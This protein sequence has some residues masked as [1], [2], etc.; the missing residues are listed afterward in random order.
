MN[1]NEKDIQVT[2]ETL[3]AIAQQKKENYNIA[4]STDPDVTVDVKT[5]ENKT[6]QSKSSKKPVIHGLTTITPETETDVHDNSTN[7][8]ISEDVL[9]DIGGKPFEITDDDLKAVLPDVDPETFQATTEKIRMEIEK[10]RK[11]LIINHGMTFE[12]ADKAAKARALKLASDENTAYLEK[13]P[14]V[15]IIEIDKTNQDKI[16]FTEEERE[17]ISK[18]KA[19]QLVIVEDTELKTIPVEKVDKK[20]KS[21]YIQTIDGNLS[22]YTI[23]LPLTSDFMTFKGAQIIQLVST[24]KYNDEHIAEMINK[25]ASLLYDRFAGGTH[26]KK[27][28]DNGT[29]IMSYNDFINQYYFHDID[30]GLFGV[31]VA[32]SPEEVETNLRCSHCQEEFV[33]KYNLKALLNLDNIPDQFKGYIDDII[34]HKY[35]E[36]YLKRMYDNISKAT[37][38]KSPFSNNIFDIAFPSIGR[39]INIYKSI[40]PTDETMVYLSAI[41]LFVH[42]LYIYNNSSGKYVVIETDEYKELLEAL[43]LLPQTDIDML[44]S[45]IKSKLYTPEFRL[46]SKCPHCGHDMVNQLSIDDL[47][48]LI[49]QDSS[50]EIRM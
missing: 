34:G 8:E 20:H 25:K 33:W 14:K 50:K 4:N 37:R 49:A 44:V 43:Q 35:D 27:Y 18:V 47:V 42:E 30:L 38:A 32:S 6:P 21:S 40:D 23:P 36:E 15:G 41:A 10:Y 5:T 11:G 48:F 39:A 12:E 19:I 13:H 17:K 26:I 45:F 31:F 28:D 7:T 2:D 3:A 29:V 16:E 22:K 1:K 24:V 46:K 9:G